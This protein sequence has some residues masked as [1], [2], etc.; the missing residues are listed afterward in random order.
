M[1]S[2][3]NRADMA[4]NRVVLAMTEDVTTVAQRQINIYA[5][6]LDGVAGPMS[7]VV[8]LLL[9]GAPVGRVGGGSE[10]G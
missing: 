10:A 5:G 7:M 4:V 1:A 2:S 6:L 3:S 8:E 9:R